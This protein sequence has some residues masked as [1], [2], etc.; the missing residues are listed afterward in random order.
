MT[1]NEIIKALECCCEAQNCTLCIYNPTKY[2]KGTISCCNEL[3]EN[4]IDLINR[5]KTEIEKLLQKLQQ[6]QVEAIK[7]F[8]EKL[9][10]EVDFVDTTRKLKQTI[11]N[12]VKEITESE[13]E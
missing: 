10:K 12:L 2:Q 9:K 13:G 1:D 8:A 6:P 3:M 11:N 7:E 4:T 5:Q